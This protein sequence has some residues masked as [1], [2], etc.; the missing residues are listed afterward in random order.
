[1][2]DPQMKDRLDRV[3]RQ[4]AKMGV[5]VMVV[6]SAD[7]YLNEYVPTDESARVWITGFTGSMGEVLITADAAYL[8]VDGRYW[9]QADKEVDTSAWTVLKVP[10][11]TGVDQALATQLASLAREG[12]QKKIKVGF[13]PE[14][15][16]PNV[17]DRLKAAAGGGFTWKPLFP[18]PVEQAR[19][20][21]RPPA[22]DAGIRVVDEARVGATVGDK[23]TR[24]ADEVEALGGDALLV[25]KL[26]QIAYL[27]NL[28]GT[29][30]PYQATFKCI[31][32]ATRE[33]L[34]VGIDPARVPNGIRVARDR[35]CV[36]AV[37]VGQ[38]YGDRED[39]ATGDRRELRLNRCFDLGLVAAEGRPTVGAAEL[40]HR[41]AGRAERK[42]HRDGEN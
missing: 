2:A 9:V 24:L 10:M 38:R 7:R 36:E 18:S 15:I 39:L 37:Q 17:L 3:R 5:D 35:P 11:G 32:L 1:M 8:A 34:F 22:R 40:G 26:D 13:E 31:A 33:T 14:R 21:E 28:R 16:T 6:R 12:S 42:R 4:M 19:G 20:A 25:Q 41:C 23:L 29:E 27:A 30:L